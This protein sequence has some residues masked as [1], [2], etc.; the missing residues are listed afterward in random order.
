MPERALL[1]SEQHPRPAG[2]LDGR[3]L[4]GLGP[5]QQPVDQHP[6]RPLPGGGALALCLLRDPVG[7]LLL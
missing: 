1:L 6:W 7:V 2:L 3:S 4:L 5:T